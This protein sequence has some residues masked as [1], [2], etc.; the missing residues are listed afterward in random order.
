MTRNEILII[1][2]IIKKNID[3]TKIKIRRKT[4]IQNSL[5]KH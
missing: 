3:L 4:L 5:I 1:E 2:E